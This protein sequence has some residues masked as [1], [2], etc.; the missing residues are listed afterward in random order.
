MLPAVL[1]VGTL[2]IGSLAAGVVAALLQAE[3]RDR[4]RLAGWLLI[5]AAGMPGLALS[6]FYVIGFPAALLLFWC[7]AL[8]S[9]WPTLGAALASTCAVA[10]VVGLVALSIHDGSSNFVNIVGSGLAIMS[11]VSAVFAVAKL[12]RELG[13][14]TL[15]RNRRA[16]DISAAA[17]LR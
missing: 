5:G 4:R 9:R 8:T 13:R 10:V 15:W 7:A 3:W 1:L 12:G 6:F 14:A 17:S 16:P 2:C 11:S